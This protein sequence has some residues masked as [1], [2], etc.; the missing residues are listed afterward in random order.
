MKYAVHCLKFECSCG[1]P[2]HTVKIGLGSLGELICTWKCLKCSKNVM[3]RLPFEE[4][5]KGIPPHPVIELP[6]ATLTADDIALLGQMHI[7][8]G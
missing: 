4:L 7:T 5:I 1:H 2:R 8:M 3:V 6:A